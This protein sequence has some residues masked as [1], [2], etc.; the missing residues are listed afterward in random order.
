MWL[1]LSEAI[2]MSIVTYM[3]IST[4]MSDQNYVDT[5][6]ETENGN[7]QESLFVKDQQNESVSNRFMRESTT[8]E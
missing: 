8:Q 1:F 3:A 2:L 4:S 6:V 5:T 7:D